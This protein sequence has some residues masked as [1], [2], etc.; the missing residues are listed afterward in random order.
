[1]TIRSPNHHHHPKT[2]T[3]SRRHRD[4]GDQNLPYRPP[5]FDR[6]TTPA[7]NRAATSSPPRHTSANL[8]VVDLQTLA[9]EPYESLRR[10]NSSLGLGQVQ[11]TTDDTL[12][13]P[14]FEL[15]T[16]GLSQ[17]PAS[18]IQATP[19]EAIACGFQPFPPSA[20]PSLASLPISTVLDEPF[21]PAGGVQEM[22]YV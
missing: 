11:N 13:L 1:M 20:G 3:I 14:T 12:H 19:R 4:R 9:S 17:L 21:E 15:T 5:E 2:S 18:E 8:Q 7:S 22:R 6:A 10:R 16:Y